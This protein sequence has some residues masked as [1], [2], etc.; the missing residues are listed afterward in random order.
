MCVRAGDQEG[1]NHT[2]SSSTSSVTQQYIH[3]GPKFN[4]PTTL[5]V[6]CSKWPLHVI[7]VLLLVLNSITFSSHLKGQTS[8]LLLLLLSEM[9]RKGICLS[10]QIWDN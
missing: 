7:Y 6:F 9:G 1:D 2:L 3:A 8:Q 5:C 4:E 10:F